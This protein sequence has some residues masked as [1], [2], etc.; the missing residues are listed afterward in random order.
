MFMN[1]RHLAYEITIVTKDPNSHSGIL[2]LARYLALAPHLETLEFHVN[3]SCL[4]SCFCF[5]FFIDE[6]L[7]RLLI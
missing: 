5:S 1:L 3:V 4:L 6:H 7:P 2:Q